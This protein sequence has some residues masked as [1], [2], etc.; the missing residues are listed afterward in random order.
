MATN[1]D[2]RRKTNSSKPSHVQSKQLTGKSFIESIYCIGEE[3]ISAVT[4]C[5]FRVR[6][7]KRS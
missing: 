5:S 1:E 4:F 6:W 7:L 2:E 3:E